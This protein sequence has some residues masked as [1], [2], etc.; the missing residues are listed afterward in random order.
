MTDSEDSKRKARDSAIAKVKALLAKT[1]E[2]GATEAEA[3][4]AAQKAAELMAKYDLSTS[5]FDIRESEVSQQDRPLDPVMRPHA[6]RVAIE[7]AQLTGARFW[8]DGPGAAARVGTFFGITHEVEIAGYLLDI[9]EGAMRREV[10]AYSRQTALFVKRK[11]ERMA[12]SFLEGMASRLSSRLR[13][14][15]RA[16]RSTGTSLVVVRDEIIEQAIKDENWKFSDGRI[17]L[18]DT[19]LNSFIKGQVAGD[20]V[21]IVPGMRGTAP[22]E[23]LR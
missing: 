21:S 7:I 2:N 11:R 3:I 15:A 14:M 16:R 9:C 22:S 12:Y 5:E 10:A 6:I 19:D 8:S 13:E 20:G 23:K 17:G 1:V 18:R 4:A